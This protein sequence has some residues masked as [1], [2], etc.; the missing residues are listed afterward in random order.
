MLGAITGDIIGS[1][2]EWRPEKDISKVEVFK[3]GSMYTDDTVA[4]IGISNALLARADSFKEISEI[5]QNTCLPYLHVKGG[6]GIDFCHWILGHKDGPYNSWGNGSAMRIS[7]VGWLSDSIED[8]HHK[9][10]AV[11]EITHNHPEGI[12]GAQAVAVAIRMLLEGY[13]RSEVKA[14]IE[15]KYLYDLDRSV[16]SIRETYSFEVS[17]QRTVP[18]AF[19]C[20]LQSE[21]YEDCVK[22]AI[23]LGGDADT[24]A[25]IAGGLYEAYNGADAAPYITKGMAYLPPELRTQVSAFEDACRNKVFEKSD[26]RDLPVY[27]PPA[28]PDPVL[29]MQD[30]ERSKYMEEIEKIDRL[31]KAPAPRSKISFCER[32]RRA[33]KSFYS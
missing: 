10:K 3:D 7:A 12:R 16:E 29:A 21:S 32:I 14:A 26:Y 9:A 13:D 31:M 11:T 25:C 23:S 2:Y 20:F 28:K 17:C 5:L 30:E 4:S 19:C 1:D 15:E 24:L 8:A 6:F 22:K 33:I 27:V 18:E